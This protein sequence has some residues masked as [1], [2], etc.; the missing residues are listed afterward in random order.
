[1]VNVWCMLD[2]LNFLSLRLPKK[3]HKV[4]ITTFFFLDF[5]AMLV[6]KVKQQVL[7]LVLMLNYLVIPK[8]SCWLFHLPNTKWTQS[9]YLTLSKRK[10]A[11]YFLESSTSCL[12]QTSPGLLHKRFFVENEFAIQA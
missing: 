5:V 4:L 1:M 10:K 11:K 9:F 2:M 6:L 3:H 12:G 8:L 7:S